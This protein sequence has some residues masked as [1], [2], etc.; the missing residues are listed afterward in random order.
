MALRRGLQVELESMWW[1]EGTELYTLKN[2]IKNGDPLTH[3]YV[4]TQIYDTKQEKIGLLSK[5]ERM[6]LI[7]YYQAAHIAQDQLNRIDDSDTDS[8]SIREKF[9]DRTLPELKSRR[10]R[11]VSQVSARTTFL[12][13]LRTR[14]ANFLEDASY[15]DISRS[16]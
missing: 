4:P 14:F 12:G 15:E 9:T 8:S 2:E 7:R 10:E 3:T 13:R 16:S 11:A 5:P 1:V 6:A